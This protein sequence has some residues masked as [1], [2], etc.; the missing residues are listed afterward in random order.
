[1][2]WAR[3]WQYQPN[4]LVVVI[5]A[6]T[7]R[8]AGGNEAVLLFYFS[9]ILIVMGLGWLGKGMDKQMGRVKEEYTKTKERREKKGLGLEE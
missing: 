3:V 1:L 6:S 4:L 7:W 5:F 9:L 8:D 2:I